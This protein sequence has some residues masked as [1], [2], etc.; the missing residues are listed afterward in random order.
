[1]REIGSDTASH[2]P[3]MGPT[4]PDNAGNYEATVR[5]VPTQA[6]LSRIQA[7][8]MKTFTCI[9]A[10]REFAVP[11]SPDQGTVRGRVSSKIETFP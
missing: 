7:R 3:D 4:G 8:Q 6:P 1:M 5:P 10:A 9:T 11:K 2:W